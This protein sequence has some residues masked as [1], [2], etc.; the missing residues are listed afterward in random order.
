MEGQTGTQVISRKVGHWG[1]NNKSDDSGTCEIKSFPSKEA[2]Q[3]PHSPGTTVR[4]VTHHG[5]FQIPKLCWEHYSGQLNM[6]CRHALLSE[7]TATHQL[8]HISPRWLTYYE[9]DLHKWQKEIQLTPC[10][11]LLRRHWAHLS[12]LKEKYLHVK[13]EETLL[14]WG[15]AP[16]EGV[17]GFSLFDDICWATAAFVLP[18]C[19]MLSSWDSSSPTSLLQRSSSSPPFTHCKEGQQQLNCLVYN[20]SSL[21]GNRIDHSPLLV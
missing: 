17:W 13:E 21:Y 5:G 2:V 20:P 7:P 8:H 19:C 12:P 9:G 6:G 11:C 1:G 10:L 15:A 4:M 16:Q 3:K 18:P 14:Q